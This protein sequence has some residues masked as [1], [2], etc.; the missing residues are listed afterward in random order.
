[1]PRGAR[2]AVAEPDARDARMRKIRRAE[3]ERDENVA[4]GHQHAAL[5]RHRELRHVGED[6]I[7]ERLSA[8]NRQRRERLAHRGIARRAARIAARMTDEHATSAKVAETLQHVHRRAKT[9]HAAAAG[10]RHHPH[11]K[12][13]RQTSM[14]APPLH[15]FAVAARLRRICG[16]DHNNV[17]HGT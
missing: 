7:E 5:L 17:K 9:S 14:R 10:I 4:A 12:R 3:V 6:E 2:G 11:L 1:M 15:L 16:R 8:R 13:C